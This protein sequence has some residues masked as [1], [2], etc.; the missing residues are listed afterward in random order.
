[1][2]DLEL[3]NPLL[4]DGENSKDPDYEDDLL[5]ALRIDSTVK[6]YQQA[7]LPHVR[8]PSLVISLSLPPPSKRLADTHQLSHKFHARR[9][10]Q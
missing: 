1:M 7:L 6:P 8:V 4:V 2:G 9:L 5:D 10:P 3:G